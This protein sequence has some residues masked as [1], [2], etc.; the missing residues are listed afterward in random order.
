VVD[1]GLAPQVMAWLDFYPWPIALGPLRLVGPSESCLGIAI[2]GA[3][4]ILVFLLLFI[5]IFFLF[6][7]MRAPSIEPSIGYGD[8]EHSIDVDFSSPLNRGVLDYLR[9]SRPKRKAGLENVSP[10][11]VKNPLTKTETHPEVGERLWDELAASLPVDC[12]WIV[13]G[14]PTLV[15]PQAGV[16]FGVAIG[17]AYC[18]CLTDADMERALKAGAS[19]ETRWSNGSTLDLASQFGPGWVFGSWQQAEL[20]WC[21]A[22]YEALGRAATSGEPLSR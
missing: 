9:R 7:G 18:L 19:T 5:F 14:A 8:G 15:H 4:V 1:A 16:V 2:V 12:R 21:R 20:E 10:A 17:M 11:S 22:E 3:L 13:C 6:S